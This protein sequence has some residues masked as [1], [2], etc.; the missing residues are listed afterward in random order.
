MTE[1]VASGFAPNTLLTFALV[2]WD[3]R[4]LFQNVLTVTTDADGTWSGD[5]PRAL[6]TDHIFELQAIGIDA[7]GAVV[8]TPPE[9][10]EYLHY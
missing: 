7:T 9:A 5:Y 1:L 6:F 2:K 4:P 10:I 8:S 3:G